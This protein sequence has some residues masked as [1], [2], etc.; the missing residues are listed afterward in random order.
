MPRIAQ[1]SRGNDLGSCLSDG[2]IPPDASIAFV[3]GREIPGLS[4]T[5]ALKQH[6]VFLFSQALIKPTPSLISTCTP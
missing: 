6:E 4:F 2:F 5:Y 3:V 1:P